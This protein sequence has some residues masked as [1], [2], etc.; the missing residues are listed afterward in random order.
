MISMK[1]CI[2]FDHN[3]FFMWTLVAITLVH[4]LFL[5]SIWMQCLHKTR[6]MKVLLSKDFYMRILDF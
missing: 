6:W 4:V 5:F 2:M 1:D 3:L